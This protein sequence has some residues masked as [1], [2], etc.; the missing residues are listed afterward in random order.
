MNVLIKPRYYMDDFDE[1]L[2]LS[3]VNSRYLAEDCPKPTEAVIFDRDEIKSIITKSLSF[4]GFTD[5]EEIN[6]FKINGSN[7]KE[8]KLLGRIEFN[9]VVLRFQTTFS[10]L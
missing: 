10:T 5:L 6:S 1:I 9:N 2:V 3:K 4:F 8:E 7:V